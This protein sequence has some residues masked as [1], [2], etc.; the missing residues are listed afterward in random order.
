MYNMGRGWKGLVEQSQKKPKRAAVVKKK[1]E[2]YW[3][4]FSVWNP[5]KNNSMIS[6]SNKKDGTE[7]SCRYSF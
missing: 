7:R 5:D 1:G 4:D 2:G 6:W 3:W